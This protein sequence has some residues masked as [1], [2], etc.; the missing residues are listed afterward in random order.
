MRGLKKNIY[1]KLLVITGLILVLLIPTTMV[2]NLILER[3]DLQKTSIKEVSAKWGQSQTISG[4]FISIPYDKYVNSFTERGS[5]YKTVK[6][7]SWLHFLPEKLEVSGSITPEKRYR[8]I[9]EVVLY[10][11]EFKIKGVFSDFNF[12]KFDIDKK[13]VHFEKS[14]L[15]I[16]ISDL[17]G[18]ENQLTLNW[19]DNVSSFSSGVSTTNIVSTGINSEVSIEEEAAVGYSFSTSINLNGSQSLYFTPVGKTTDINIK[20]NW[21][22]PSFTGSYLPDSREVSEDGFVA[23]WNILHLNRNYPQS[24]INASYSI[25]KS[26]FGTDLLLPVDNYKKSYRVAKYAILFLLLTFTTF[27]FVEILKNIFIHPIQYLLVG[28]ALVIFYTLLVSFSEHLKFN[29]S[30]ILSSFLTLFLIAFYTKAVT[31][32]NQISMLVSGILIILYAFIFTIIQ[33][34]DYA[35]LIGSLGMFTILGIIMYTSRKIDW[36][37]L[38]VNPKKT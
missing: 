21:E 29:A 37:N 8:G 12:E 30:Y 10:E 6:Q 11:S 14:T 34:E 2:K 28:L 20:S 38:K 4:P 25:R 26:E 35:L 23:N 18:I 1:L 31:K 3:E 7:K 9:F 32:N 5:I 17:K 16:G 13:D 19:N 36:A 24:W 33:L 15:N 27:F 22:T